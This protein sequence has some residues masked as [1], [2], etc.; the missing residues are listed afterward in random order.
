[1]NFIIIII[2]RIVPIFLVFNHHAIVFVLVMKIINDSLELLFGLP[3]TSFC[4]GIATSKRYISNPTLKYTP[5]LLVVWIYQASYNKGISVCLFLQNGGRWWC[6]KSR[7]DRVYWMLED[8]MEDSLHY[9][10]CTVSRA[11]R[12]PI[13]LWHR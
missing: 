8:N 1:M 3:T 11:W 13:W 4:Y 2:Q 7:Q 9:E 6:L 10:A 5:L 12:A